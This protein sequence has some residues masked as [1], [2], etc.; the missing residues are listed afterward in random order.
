MK[1][2]MNIAVFILFFGIALVEAVQSKNW[3]L[4]GLFFLVGLVFLYGDIVKKK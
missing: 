2:G 4:A 1:L 3:P